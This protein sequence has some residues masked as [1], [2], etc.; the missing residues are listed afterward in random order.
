MNVLNFNFFMLFIYSWIF[1]SFLSKKSAKKL[2]VIFQTIQ[3]II[4]T[5][6]R[7]KWIGVDSERYA[8]FFGEIAQIDSL[9]GLINYPM[10][11]GYIF[12]QKFISIFSDSYT[13]YF[14][15]VASITYIIIGFIIYRY[16]SSA[17]LSYLLFIALGFF[18]FN[19]SGMRQGL[20]VSL[21]LLGFHYM[22]NKD[23]KKYLIAIALAVSVHYSAII[24]LPMYFIYNYKFKKTTLY[25]S[26]CLY[27]VLFLFR[28]YLGRIFSLLYF[29][30]DAILS[31]YESTNTIGGLAIMIML[32]L[33]AC[34]L[35]QNTFNT[36]NRNIKGLLNL[37]IISLFLQTFSSFSYLF[38]RLNFFYMIYLILLIPETVWEPTM[39]VPLEEKK[40]FGYSKLVMFT[41]II[42]FFSIYYIYGVVNNINEILP[43]YFYW[44]L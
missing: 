7:S 28:N 21:G 3:M 5:G 29:E 13:F 44:Q 12:L 19:L 27:I 37:G 39:G 22:Y 32:I 17:F 26:I 33:F 1:N 36:D 6:F 40:Y 35:L 20:A 10:E 23:I 9:K 8:R 18:D 25:L 24:L 38:T 15:L 16:S 43:Y 2:L 41:I 14:F 31:Q 4:I 11:I 30:S 42:V 34:G